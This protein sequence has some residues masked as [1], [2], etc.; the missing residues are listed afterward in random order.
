VL[1]NTSLHHAITWFKQYD[2]SGYLR[3]DYI[4]LKTNYG[5]VENYLMKTQL[6]FRYQTS[7]NLQII[8]L[9]RHLEINLEVSPE[10]ITISILNIL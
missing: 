6:L 2:V 7:L 8:S 9:S 3:C 1:T 4:L 10:R 5:A